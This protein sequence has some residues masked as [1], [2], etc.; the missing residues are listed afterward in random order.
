MK[1]AFDGI[2]SRPVKAQES[3]HLKV[4]SMETKPIEFQR[5]K[6]MISRTEYL[7]TVG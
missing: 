5:E 3:V 2:I 1:N 6:R 7:R 4:I